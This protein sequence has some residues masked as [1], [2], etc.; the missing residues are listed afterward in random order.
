M[1]QY[2]Q[3]ASRRRIAY[4]QLAGTGP[5]VVFLGGLMSD[6]QGSKA[7]YLH[8]WAH[9]AGRAFLRLDYS[10]HGQSGGE[11]ADGAISDWAQDA[12]QTICNLTR[13]PQ[14]LVGSSMGGWISLIL[15]QRIPEKVAGFVGIATAA[16]FTEDGYWAGF[17]S[18]QRSELTAGRPIFLPSDYGDP[19][20]VTQRMITEGR[21]HLVLRQPMVLDFPVRFLQGSADTVVTPDLALQILHHADGDDIRLTIVKGAD[22]SFSTP[23]CLKLIAENITEVLGLIS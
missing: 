19:Y 13:G 16:D 18:K 3:T 11:F 1:P 17:S 20:I 10:G 4:E 15:A 2:L 21:K 6:M 8:D 12:E 23:D 9:A 22:H 14:L 7:Q 5:G